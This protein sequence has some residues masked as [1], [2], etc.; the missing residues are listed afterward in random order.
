MIDIVKLRV[1]GGNGGDGRVSFR[2]EKYAAKGG[3][4]GGNGGAGG[5]VII[6][7]TRHMATL[8]HLS[9]L[10][11]IEAVSGE[12]GGRKNCFG[13]NGQDTI[14]E[15]PLG[16][17]VWQLSA[18]SVAQHR[19]R[20]G[21]HQVLPKGEVR[22]RRYFLTE[23]GQP[24]PSRDP[25]T[26]VD[27]DMPV[28]NLNIAELEKEELLHLVEDGQEVVL[29]QGG[30]G[31]RG[32]TLF[33]SSTNTTPLEAEYGTIGE[34][35]VV[36][37]ELKLLADVGLV[38]L[39]N[40]GKS[41]FL[42]M[43]TNAH[44]K[45]ANYPFTT[46]EPHLG[47][48][49]VPKHL[50]PPTEIV[51]ADIPGLIEGASQGQGL[52]FDFLRHVEGCRVLAYILFLEETVI[53]DEELPLKAKAEQLVT[54]FQSLRSELE[55]YNPEL[56]ER[57]AVIAVSKADLIFEELQTEVTKVFKKN[58]LQLPIFFS[59]ATQGNLASLQEALVR[60]LT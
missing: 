11:K 13:K 2:R 26:V 9:H 60:K 47:I 36:L 14:I 54:Q 35:R 37:L 25:D 38:G 27:Q 1:K 7:A 59:G 4:N 40:A 24:I 41:T 50:Q 51:I 15:V 49:A 53:Y 23:E 31:G 3:P 39:P 8:L 58:K 18:N 42:S 28:K 29:C 12:L 43:V 33:K 46:L 55:K 22:S 19:Q 34:E 52:G 5:S 32:N 17:V 16:T 44:P 10:K 6:R 30:F 56:L 57:P 20:F 21:L 45:V 48:M